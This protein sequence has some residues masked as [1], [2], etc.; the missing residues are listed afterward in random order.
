[1]KG[2][3]R[4]ELF[5][6]LVATQLERGYRTAALFLGSQTEAE[7]AIQDALLRA[8]QRL[9]DLRSEERIDSWFGRILV[10]V[11][12]DRLR[13]RRSIVRWAPSHV[14]TNDPADKVERDQLEA[15]L[16]DLSPDH[17]IAVV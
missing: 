12:R 8:W 15:A 11:C 2:I 13:S 1:M 7:D 4:E 6:R 17:R 16:S 14:A 5:A 3:E 9:P 10:N